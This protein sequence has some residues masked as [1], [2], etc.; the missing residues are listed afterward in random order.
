MP[1][2]EGWLLSYRGLG[3]VHRQSL[4]I[5]RAS[6]A[7]SIR[8]C[9]LNTSV[10]IYRWRNRLFV[11]S[12]VVVRLDLNVRT[13]GTRH[14]RLLLCP[15]TKNVGFLNVCTKIPIALAAGGHYRFHS[16]PYKTALVDSSKSRIQ[17]EGEAGHSRSRSSIRFALLSHYYY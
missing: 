4:V 14:D 12:F 17:S 7:S 10:I 2:P 3:Q 6:K 11:R 15:L 5:A 13:R 9:H 16:L 1:L 8:T